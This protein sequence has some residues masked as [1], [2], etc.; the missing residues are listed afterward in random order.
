MPTIPIGST[1]K[2][3]NTRRGFPAT[4]RYFFFWHWKKLFEL[5]S[6]WSD[7]SLFSEPFQ[8]GIFCRQQDAQEFLRYLLE[9]LH[10][11]VNR[12]T[13]RPK[14]EL[15]DIPDHLEDGQKAAEAWKRYLR[16]DDSKIVE[17]YVGQLKSS[18][19]CENCRNCSVTFD[20]FW[21]I[22]LPISSGHRSSLSDSNIYNCLKLFTKKEIMDGDE[23]P[24]RKSEKVEV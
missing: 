2:F 5:V 8:K 19:T 13:V 12:V 1:G 7:V 15:T 10:E 16:R 17:L 24:V 9:G 21:D 14:P 3:S 18:L 4:C 22:A 20:P 23:R 6:L 11:D